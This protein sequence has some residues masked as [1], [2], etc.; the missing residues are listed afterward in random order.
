VRDNRWNVQS[1]R[2]SSFWRST[3]GQSITL[4]SCCFSCCCWWC[5]QRRRRRWCGE[6]GW[7]WGWGWWWWRWRGWRQG[8]W[9]RCCFFYCCYRCCWDWRLQT[10]YGNC[11]YKNNNVIIHSSKIKCFLEADY[12]DPA[13]FI[14]ALYYTKV[15]KRNLYLKSSKKWWA[16]YNHFQSVRDV[17]LIMMSCLSF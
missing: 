2:V 9:W 17:N 11:A 4:W 8:W 13:F 14:Y 6:G 5:W 10:G 16:S 12:T 1:T 15:F 3:Q 7:E